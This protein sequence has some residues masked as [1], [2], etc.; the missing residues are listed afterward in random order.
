MPEISDGLIIVAKRDCPTCVL[1]E[2][3][4][5]ELAASGVALA[6][7]SQDDPSFPATVDGVIDDTNL[8]ASYRLDIETVPTLIRMS[9]GKEVARIVGWEMREW[10]D[11]TGIGDL[12]DGLPD[13]RPGCGS[14]NV[15][16]GMAETLA[17]RF[18]DTKLAARRIE[19]A[20]LEDDIESCFERGWSDG[21]PVVPPTEVRIVRMLA[22]TTRAPDEIIGPIPPNLA[23]CTVEKVAINAVMAGCKPEYLPV[24]LA[25]IE[26]ALDPDFCMHGLLCT[27]HFAGPMVI[28][29]GPVARA[30]GMNSSGNALGQGNR[31]NATIGRALQLVIRNVG[32]GVPGG[33]DRATL[34]NPGKYTFCFAEDETDPVWEPLSVERGVAAGKSAVTLYAAEGLLGSSDD[35]SRTPESLTR[36]LA[37]SLRVVGHPKKTGAND[38]LLIVAQEHMQIYSEAGWSKARVLAAFDE[39]LRLPGKDL[40]VGAGGVAAGLP[41]SMANETVSKFRPGGLTIVRAGGIAGRMSAIVGGWGASGERGSVMVTRE[42]GT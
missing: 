13:Y 33:I 32:G 5:G 26:A 42:I 10:R 38:A 16:P 25:A 36:S 7:Y 22:G 12:G 39:A 21:L 34:G 14:L 23:P 6:V 19:I 1:L 20:P 24:V 2:P 28:V 40:V 41:E 18:G 3:V 11:F 8:E 27:T 4:Y 35:L 9:G 31:A 15:E 29:N 30:I 17:V 37:L